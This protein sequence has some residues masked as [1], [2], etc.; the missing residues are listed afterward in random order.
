[1][2][3]SKVKK[4]GQLRHCMSPEAARPGPPD[5]SAFVPLVRAQQTSVSDRLTVAIHEDT[6]L[7]AEPLRQFLPRYDTSAT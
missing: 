7:V 2:R 1:M 4:I 5:M 3:A 6:Q